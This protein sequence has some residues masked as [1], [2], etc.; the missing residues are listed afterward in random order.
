MPYCKK[1]PDDINTERGF[2]GAELRSERRSAT[3]ISSA[4]VP[5]TSSA[6]VPGARWQNNRDSRASAHGHCSIVGQNCQIQNGNGKL[7]N[8]NLTYRK[9][10]TD[11]KLLQLQL[12][13]NAMW[14]WNKAVFNKNQPEVIRGS[15]KKSVC[16]DATFAQTTDT[17]G[18]TVTLKTLYLR[19]SQLN[20]F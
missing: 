16:F 3:G 19:F 10:G 7:A 6:T 2:N 15:D 17:V 12:P 8:S 1:H 20:S 13:Y 5:G 11:G 18:P 14:Q 9:I 4:T